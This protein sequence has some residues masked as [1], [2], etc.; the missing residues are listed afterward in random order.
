VEVR[1]E[2]VLDP[3]TVRL[4]V[5]QVLIDVALRIDDRGPSAALVGDEI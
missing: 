4:G 3:A 5:E 1:Q 2:Y